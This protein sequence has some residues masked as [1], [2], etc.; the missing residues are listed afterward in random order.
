MK[1]ARKYKLLENNTQSNND[2]YCTLRL[3]CVHNVRKK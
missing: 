1:T 3:F 2:A